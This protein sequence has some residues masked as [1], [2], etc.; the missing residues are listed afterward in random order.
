MAKCIIKSQEELS[1]GISIYSAVFEADDGYQENQKYQ[2]TEAQL[3][4]ALTHFNDT[5]LE[6]KAQAI[7]TN[8]LDNEEVVLTVKSSQDAQDSLKIILDNAE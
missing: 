6:T 2:C 7:V 8:S 5:H 3:K 1:G 4:D